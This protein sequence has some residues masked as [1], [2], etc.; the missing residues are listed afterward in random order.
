MGTLVMHADDN[1]LRVSFDIGGVL[2]KYPHVFRPMVSA[3][4]KGGAVVYVLTDIPDHAKATK[5]VWDNGFHVDADHVL[6]A[7]WN[8]HGDSCKAEVL[9]AH[10]IHLHIDDFA[11]YCAH[12][13]CLSLFAWPNPELPYYHEDF[14]HD[15]ALGVPAVMRRRK[16]RPRAGGT[17]GG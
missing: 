5:L 13:E 9:K 17:S 3:L 12:G 14:V 7:D 6:C 15:D 16:A 4:I 2:S 1:R 8:E 10:G 11:P